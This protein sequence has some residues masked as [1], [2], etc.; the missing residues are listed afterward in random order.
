MAESDTTLERFFTVAELAELTQSCE[1]FW[2]R[3]IQRGR[4][5]AIKL[6]IGLRV[7]RIDFEIY[8]EERSTD[9]DR[10]KHG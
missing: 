2:R 6:P 4:L 1:Q 8:L 10:R 9:A 7:R 3:E 5:V